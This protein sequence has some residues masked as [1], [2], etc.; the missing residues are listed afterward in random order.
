LDKNY[1]NNY[2][3][4]NNKP[5]KPTSFAKNI[6]NLIPSESRIMELGCGT[7]RDSNYFASKGHIVFACDQSEVIIE[8]LSKNNQSNPYF[9]KSSIN[10]L[11]KN[12]NDKFD[13]MYARFV[14][15]ALDDIESKEAIDWIFSN[16][17]TNGLFL[18]E[19]RSIKD[20]IFGDGD[21]VDD[22]I[23]KTTHQRRFLKKNEILKDLEEKGF[24]IDDVVEGKGL[25]IYKD[26]DP[27]VIRI[28]A[29]KA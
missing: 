2:Y 21:K 26:S 27:V 3:S 13:V 5:Q 9:F 7:G 29:R 22:R 19:S 8:N 17:K 18:S 12:I 1:W 16:L 14:L 15:H 28:I 25:A 4:K 20:S 10:Q 24:V 11:S 23:Y 6:V